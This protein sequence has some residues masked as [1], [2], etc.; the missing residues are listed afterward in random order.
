MLGIAIDN[1]SWIQTKPKAQHTL[2]VFFFCNKAPTYPLL[3]PK[4]KLPI[5]A[6]KMDKLHAS[7]AFVLSL[8]W[9]FDQVNSLCGVDDSFQTFGQKAYQVLTIARTNSEQRDICKAKGHG[10]ICIETLCGIL[11]VN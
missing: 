2:L 1:L 11:K 3:R 6:P 5:Q 7:I 4:T 8:Y 10:K 9:I